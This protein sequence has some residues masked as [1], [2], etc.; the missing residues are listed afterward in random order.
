M[1]L[2]S[3]LLVHELLAV[4]WT[5]SLLKELSLLISCWGSVIHSLTSWLLPIITNLYIF[6][7]CE[8][9]LVTSQSKPCNPEEQVQC[10]LK[11]IRYPQLSQ[12]QTG[13]FKAIANLNQLNYT[14]RGMVIFGSSLG[15]YIMD[16]GLG[17]VFWNWHRVYFRQLIGNSSNAHSNY[18]FFTISIL[19]RLPCS[20]IVRVEQL[21]I[22]NKTKPA[23]LG[24]NSTHVK[25]FTK[26]NL[27]PVAYIVVPYTPSNTWHIKKS[28]IHGTALFDSQPNW[29]SCHLTVS[30]DSGTG[31]TNRFI[32]AL[33]EDF[34]AKL[35]NKFNKFR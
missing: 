2:C 17:R 33:F 13:K 4:T 11:I 7:F 5:L 3:F 34:C 21:K 26:V 18:Q 23:S 31:N 14:A 9:S 22:C 24:S 30:D 6:H 12:C 10:F 16:E 20:F 35:I 27:E 15:R 8:R 25:L 1:G 29:W 28:S 19:V 32:K